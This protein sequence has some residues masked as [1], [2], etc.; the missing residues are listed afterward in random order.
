MRR[1]THSTT[2]TTTSNN[3]FKL[4]MANVCSGASCMASN[5]TNA[6]YDVQRVVCF[7]PKISIKE[8][9]DEMNVSCVR[10]KTSAKCTNPMDS[11][12]V[13]IPAGAIIDS[14]EYFGVDGFQTS[15]PFTIGLGTLNNNI[16]LPLI[17]DGTQ[18]IANTS[19]GGCRHFFSI[20][21][22]GACDRNV[23]LYS[24]K[25]NVFFE[26]PLLKGRLA[27]IVSYHRRPE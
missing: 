20:N 17:L 23:V 5:K 21:D 27:I 4:P 14:V 12:L 1:S 13:E 22:S 2:T 16:S 15:Q 24:G 8:N 6:V 7:T 26:S 9:V 11:K 18:E 10:D 3:I 19:T 25:I